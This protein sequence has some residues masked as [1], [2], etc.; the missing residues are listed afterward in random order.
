MFRLIFRAITLL[1]LVAGILLWK[2]GLTPE[3]LPSG[4]AGWLA[5]YFDLFHDPVASTALLAACFL[6]AAAAACV[7][8]LLLA[9]VFSAL[10]AAI[11]LLCLIGFIGARFPLF[12]AYMEHLFR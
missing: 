8:E 6:L 1:S 4:A 2:S 10:S 7:T 5:A 3:R 12:A 11:S 9:L